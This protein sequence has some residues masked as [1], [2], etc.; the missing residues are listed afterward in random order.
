MHNN[1][2][3]YD[4]IAVNSFIAV[5]VMML[6]GWLLFKY[7]ELRKLRS[8]VIIIVFMFVECF[9]EEVKKIIY[10]YCI[11]KTIQKAVSLFSKH[12]KLYK[13]ALKVN[14]HYFKL[15]W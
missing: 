13:P 7:K 6:Y 12:W 15:H 2:Y 3:F 9:T 14:K 11:A 1:V 5:Y 4:D 10:C 8:K